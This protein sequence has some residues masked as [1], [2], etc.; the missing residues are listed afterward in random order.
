MLKSGRVKLL[1]LTGRFIVDV[2]GWIDDTVT[3]GITGTEEVVIG[4]FGNVGVGAAV[5]TTVGTILGRPIDTG[6]GC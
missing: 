1:K 3:A 4:T 5:E 2:G 6:G